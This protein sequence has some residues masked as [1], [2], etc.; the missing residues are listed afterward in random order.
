V[1]SNTQKHEYLRRKSPPKVNQ[2]GDEDEEEAKENNRYQE[3]YG[4][5]VNLFEERKRSSRQSKHPTKI[6]A[7]IGN[8]I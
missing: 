6:G 8:M 2:G 5:D 7:D 1:V 4:E 3:Y